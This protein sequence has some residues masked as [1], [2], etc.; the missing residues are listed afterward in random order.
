MYPTDFEGSNTNLTKPSDMTDEQCFSLPAEKNVD[1]QGFPYFLTA[2]MPN[3]EDVEALVAGRPLFL[4]VIGQG[5]P[6]VA[7]FTVDENGEGNF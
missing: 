4:K 6:P 2:W 1:S 3:K 7:L 5:F